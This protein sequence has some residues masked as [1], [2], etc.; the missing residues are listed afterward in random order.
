MQLRINESTYLQ[1]VEVQESTSYPGLLTQVGGRFLHFERQS[2][3]SRGFGRKW[4]YTSGLLQVVLGQHVE[5][6]ILASPCGLVRFNTS[7]GL[8][9]GD[10]K[11]QVTNTP[12]NYRWRLL[13]RW[14]L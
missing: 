8:H 12:R 13:D 5:V 11:Q 10:T 14:H 2:F 9:I 7:S 6:E 4:S 1:L 3:C